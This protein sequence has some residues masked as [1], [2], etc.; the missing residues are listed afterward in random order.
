M[1][2]LFSMNNAHVAGSGDPPSF[3]N[4]KPGRYHGYFENRHGE[5]W[6]FT[7][8]RSTKKAELRSGDTGWGQVYEVIA[9]K[10]KELLLSSEE[11]RWLDACWMAAA[12][13]RE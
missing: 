13:V 2:P 12:V 9:G 4:D 5:Q 3:V 1:P 11:L 10:P 7:Y 8:D 6:V